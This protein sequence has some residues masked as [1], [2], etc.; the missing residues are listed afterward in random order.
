MP[1]VHGIEFPEGQATPVQE[2][3]QALRQRSP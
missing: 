3:I 2:L 1:Y